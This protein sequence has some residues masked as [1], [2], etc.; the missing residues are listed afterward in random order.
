MK[1]RMKKVLCVLAALVL[2]SGLV[3]LSGCGEKDD[4]QAKYYGKWKIKSAEMS[5][6][7]LD[8]KQLKKYNGGKDAGYIE[9][10]SGDKCQIEVF[11]ESGSATWSLKDETI[12]V[13]DGKSKM[14][15]KVNDDN[16]MK[17]TAK[18]AGLTLELEK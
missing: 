3:L 17:L 1:I 16:V 6:I 4:P 18:K 2:V 15:G 7:K 5:G 13:D 8:A 9:F 14:E 11:G 10:K 12:T